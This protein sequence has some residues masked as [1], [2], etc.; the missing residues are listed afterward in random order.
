MLIIFCWLESSAVILKLI[1]LQFGSRKQ[2][3]AQAI[4]LEVQISFFLLL[5]RNQSFLAVKYA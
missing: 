1:D 5:I 4:A 2:N 3:N